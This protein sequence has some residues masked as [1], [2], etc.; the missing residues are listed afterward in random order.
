LKVAALS[1]NLADQLDLLPLYLSRHLQVALLALVAGICLS[2]P[3][4]ILVH[5]V[6]ALQAPV[7]G[8]VGIIQTIPGL[9]L[10]ALMVPLL[11]LIG[12]VPAL[13]ALTLYSMLPVVQNTAVGLGS[14]D[15][16]LT[17]AGR[18]LGMTAGQLLTQVELP[19]AA[20]VILAGV[21]TA[22]V[23]TVGIATLATP[24]GWTS[25]GN[26]IFAGLQTQNTAAVLTGCI[27]AAA[28]ALVLD[29]LVRLLEHSVRRRS[30]PALLGA[31]LGLVLLAAGG[32]YPLY[33]EPSA[34]GPTA[35]IKTSAEAK[36]KVVI[37]AKTFTEQYILAD[38]LA[39]LL[40][41][42]GYQPEVLSSLG[43]T[44]VFDALKAGKVDVYVD[45]SGTIW[46]NYLK[47]D[48]TLG[49][50][51]MLRHIKA[52]LGQQ[53]IDVLPLGF[54]NA[55]CLA[56][57]GTRANDLGIMTIGDLAQHAPQLK[58]GSDYE[59]FQRPEWAAV[60]DAY[61]LRFQQQV[62]LDPTLMYGAVH[63]G[64]VDVISAYSTDGRI[65]SLYLRVLED[66]QG[67]LPPYDAVLLTRKDNP[68]PE[69]E[70][71]ALAPIS[72]EKMREANRMVDVDGKPVSEAAAWLYE[73]TLV[74]HDYVQGNFGPTAEEQEP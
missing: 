37:G 40:R 9:A 38:V 59:F 62:T 36:G 2:L 60:V 55:Y 24:V 5:R 63:E 41:D 13:I 33:A 32:L 54:E 74:E 4:G 31:S 21:R 14:I 61:G 71:F 68:L 44:V 15:P 19:L 7:L 42:S 1:D 66:P 50:E 64:Q 11:G 20:P 34:P 58:M 30:T 69:L 51:E 47:H 6:R 16:D 46:A 3:L 35:G 10:L 49:R 12:F 45:Y 67:A 48:S 18:G 26:F 28:L 52:E 56:M 72:P 39:R 22:A 43:S 57:D 25:L 73:D 29:G 65:A 23:W 53:G 70:L 8:L 17:E 27:A